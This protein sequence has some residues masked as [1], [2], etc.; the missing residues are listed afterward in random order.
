MLRNF[1]IKVTICYM[2]L[3]VPLHSQH[4]LALAREL[5]VRF[6]RGK[7]DQV[8]A[9]GDSPVTIVEDTESGKRIEIESD[10]VVLASPLVSLSSEK[11]EFTVTLDEYGFFSRQGSRE[12][13]YACGTSTGPTDIPNSVAEANSVALQVYLDLQGGA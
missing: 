9:R 5:G 10:L 7:P 6:V 4:Y 2:D 3:R 12:R 11:K 8:T 13:I 1:G